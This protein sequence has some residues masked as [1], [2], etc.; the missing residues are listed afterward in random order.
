MLNFLVD[1]F[2][3]IIAHPELTALAVL[4]SLWILLF[5]PRKKIIF[6]GAG[7]Y[8]AALVIEYAAFPAGFGFDA[9]V[10]APVA[11]ASVVFL[12]NF[13]RDLKGGIA[14]GLGFAIVENASYFA[15]LASSPLL[16]PAVIIRSTA[17]V[18][19]HA[20]GGSLSSF[21]WRKGGISRFGLLAAISF[22]SVF[23]LF[24]LSLVS[25]WQMYIFAAGATAAEAL[26]LTLLTK[27]ATHAKAL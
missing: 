1:D 5:G 14:S 11:E 15:A 8:A 2:L 4:L 10:F 9:V 3:L 17:D 23:N 7:A 22:H 19:L 18:G 21:S 25:V 24:A 12:F 6:A 27:R 26:I 13:S 16:I 20:S